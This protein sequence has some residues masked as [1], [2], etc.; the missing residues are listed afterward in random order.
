M[1]Q[2]ISPVD[3]TVYV[4]WELAESNSISQFIEL[5]RLAQKQWQQISLVERAR[6]CQS[7]VAYFKSKQTQIVEEIT[8]QMGRPVAFSG[9]EVN[10][11][12]ERAR[13]MIAIAEQSLQMLYQKQEQG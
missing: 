5:S 2:C 12:A 13:Y 11:L 10:G 4:E 9:G 7:A 8:W 3:G 6:I 1:L